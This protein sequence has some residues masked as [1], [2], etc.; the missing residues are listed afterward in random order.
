[1]H[2][3]KVETI[4]VTSKEGKPLGIVTDSDV[5]DKVVMKGID[6]DEIFFRDIMTSPILT[7][8]T[9]ATVHDA[10][11]VMIVKVIKRVPIT[12]SENQHAIVGIV[13]QV[14]L[15]NAITTSLFDK[16]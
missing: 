6:S 16:I 1:M 3:K 7:L 11:E 2:S 15:A 10:L 13:T 5:L 4:I 12:T 14:A 9:K 8:S